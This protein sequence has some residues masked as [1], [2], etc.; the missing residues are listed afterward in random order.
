MAR[1][2]PPLRPT[3]ACARLWVP[4]AMVRV[5]E[6]LLGEHAL[7]RETDAWTL[8][9][10]RI[11]QTL[12]LGEAIWYSGGRR[13][14]GEHEGRR[15][16]GGRF[17]FLVE[18]RFD[19]AGSAWNDGRARNMGSVVFC[20]AWGPCHVGWDVTDCLLHTVELREQKNAASLRAPRD[21]R[22]LCVVAAFAIATRFSALF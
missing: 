17:P 2:P 8:K 16:R 12:A 9:R 3:S 5:N 13:H 6:L 20:W 15:A 4:N 10:A 7:P 18:R 11:R 22:L 14:L 21:T 1:R 19:K